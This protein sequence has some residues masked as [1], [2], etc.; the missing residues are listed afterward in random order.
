MEN[1]IFRILNKIKFSVYFNDGLIEYYFDEYLECKFQFMF[2][3]ETNEYTITC[4]IGT[5]PK[6]LY[7]INL[8]FKDLNKTYLNMKYSKLNYIYGIYFLQLKSTMNIKRLLAYFKKKTSFGIE[9]FL[10]HYQTYQVWEMIWIKF[11][12]S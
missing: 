4:N 12:N 1:I 8:T 2:T 7:R 9:H 6:V 5:P 3:K 10:R 11:W